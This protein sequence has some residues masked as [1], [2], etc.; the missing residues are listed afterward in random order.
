MLGDDYRCHLKFSHGVDDEKIETI[1]SKLG[2][3]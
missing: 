1:I 3:T 2:S